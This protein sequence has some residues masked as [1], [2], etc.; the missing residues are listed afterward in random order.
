VLPI[1]VVEFARKELGNVA[2]TDVILALLSVKLPMLENV[3][4]MVTAVLPSVIGVAKLASRFARGMLV[5]AFAK[6]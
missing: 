5:V 4:L 1:V 3:P 2:A 6:V